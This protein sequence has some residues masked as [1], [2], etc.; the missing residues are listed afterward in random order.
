MNNN[1][2]RILVT[3]SGRGIGRASAVALANAGY[4]VV[5]HYNSS[6]QGVRETAEMMQKPCAGFLRFDVTNAAQTQ[7]V[8][9]DEIEENG[10]LWG[11]VYNSGIKR[12]GMLATMESQDWLSVIDTNLNGYY[13]VIKPMLHPM[14]RARKGGRIIAISSLSGSVGVA[15]QTNYSASKGAIEAASRSLAMELA[16]RQI[17]VNCVCPGFIKTDMLAGVGSDDLHRSVPMQ[18]LGDAHEVA[19]LV[20]FLCSDAASYIT[21]QSIRIDGGIG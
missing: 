18:R 1:E 2:K 14:M 9:A 7:Q 17:T 13:N 3:G 6:E 4:Q 20:E 15:G 16:K 11:C 10:T 21:K 8:I 19:S 5:C 12:D